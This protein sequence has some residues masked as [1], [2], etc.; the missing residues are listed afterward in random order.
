MFLNIELSYDTEGKFIANENCMCACT[1]GKK[2]RI[3]KIFSMFL[4]EI[5]YVPKAAFI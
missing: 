2:L 3:F 1:T 5:T 4:K